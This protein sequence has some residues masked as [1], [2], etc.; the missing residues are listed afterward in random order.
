MSI[1]NIENLMATS[2]CLWLLMAV[3]KA[4]PQNHRHSFVDALFGLGFAAWFSA[5]IIW[6][7]RVWV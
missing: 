1:I 3:I 4:V 5:S 2:L 6:I 7:A